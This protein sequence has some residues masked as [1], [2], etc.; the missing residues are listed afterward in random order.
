MRVM[1]I[2]DEPLALDRFQ[3]MLGKYKDVEIVACHLEANRVLPDPLL[4]QVDVVFVDIDMPQINGVTLAKK[5][6]AIY[7]DI[8]VIFATAYE[9][10]A[11]E[12][13]EIH[14]LDYLLKPIS[15][16]RLEQTIQR[17]R[18][19]LNL[20]IVKQQDRGSKVMK[21]QFFDEFKVIDPD[22]NEVTCWKSKR[23]RSFLLF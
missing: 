1:L 7:P 8:Q 5:V 16:Q 13:F 6:K 2:D 21:V 14:A 12:A 19:W 22:G 18:E 15:K 11:L 4:R 9:E 10:F 3:H 17:I 23:L 20:N